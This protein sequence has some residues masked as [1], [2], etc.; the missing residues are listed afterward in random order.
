[1]FGELD[2]EKNGSLLD[3]TFMERV[4]LVPLLAAILFLEL[5]SIEDSISV[6][7]G[8]DKDLVIS[9]HSKSPSNCLLAVRVYSMVL[10]GLAC[11]R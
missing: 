8:G 2:K 1:M 7:F 3:M 5:R 9:A 6:G 11:P 4:V 10:A